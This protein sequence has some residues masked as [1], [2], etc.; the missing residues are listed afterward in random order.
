MT[1]RDVMAK[2]M[3]EEDLLT[4]CINLAQLLGW[5]VAHFRPARTAKGWRTAMQGDTGFPDLVLVEPRDRWMRPIMW[6]E[7]KSE[8]GT[9]SPDQ[10]A[11]R[12]ALLLAGQHEAVADQI[13]DALE[14][15]FGA[16]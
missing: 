9:L 6:V 12:D 13:G 2:A 15:F 4:C 1:T 14:K 11:W 3:S 8:K 10:E 7:L 16:K 5:R